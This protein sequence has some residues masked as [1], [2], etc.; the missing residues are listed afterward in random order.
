M[1]AVDTAPTLYGV[2]ELLTKDRDFQGFA[3][4]KTRDPL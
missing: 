1:M 3:Q 2:E 4:L